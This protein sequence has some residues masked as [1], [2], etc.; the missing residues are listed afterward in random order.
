M[1]GGRIGKKKSYN[2]GR[3]R[4]T[5]ARNKIK[6]LE[7]RGEAAGP[8]KNSVRYAGGRRCDGAEKRRQGTG[9]KAEGAK[10]HL[11]SN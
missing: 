10:R 7:H 2:R 1:G 4:E 8:L 5:S 6:S 9:W 3:R 11:S